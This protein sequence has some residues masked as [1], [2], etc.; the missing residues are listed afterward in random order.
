MLS[1]WYCRLLTSM[2]T[3]RRLWRQAVAV[4]HELFFTFLMFSAW[5]ST[6]P[7]FLLNSFFVNIIWNS[8]KLWFFMF[9]ISSACFFTSAAQSDLKPLLSSDQLSLLTLERR[10]RWRYGLV[11]MVT[12]WAS[13]VHKPRTGKQ[14]GDVKADMSVHLNLI[15]TK[16]MQ[17]WSDQLFM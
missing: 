7:F 14:F 2:Q 3:N 16:V 15:I 13:L 5:L 4:I 10:S 9:D 11:T 1:H 6:P 12:T 8:N 17:L